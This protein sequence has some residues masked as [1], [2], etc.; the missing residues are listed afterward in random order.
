MKSIISII[1]NKKLKKIQL[2]VQTG[3]LYSQHFQARKNQKSKNKRKRIN[4]KFNKIKIN[5]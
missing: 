4:Q 3:V 5:K 1:K 2:Q